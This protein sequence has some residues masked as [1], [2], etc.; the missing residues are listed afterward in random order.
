MP[1]LQDS[2]VSML[3]RADASPSE[4]SSG[5]G[6]KVAASLCS[7]EQTRHRVSRALDSV[8]RSPRFYAQESRR[9]TE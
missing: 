7:G 8:S 6:V 9:V 3:R 1:R 4:Q 2:R 5:L